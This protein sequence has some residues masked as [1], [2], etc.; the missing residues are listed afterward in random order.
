MIVRWYQRT[1]LTDWK[2]A[3]ARWLRTGGLTKVRP[4]ISERLY[5]DAVQGREEEM[6]EDA[7]SGMVEPM[8]DGRHMD[9]LD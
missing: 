1:A 6:F 4:V 9:K 2:C 8:S 3:L 5:L 7:M